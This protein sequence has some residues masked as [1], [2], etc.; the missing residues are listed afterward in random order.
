MT[1]NIIG[2]VPGC[3]S[4]AMAVINVIPN[5]TIAASSNQSL[6]CAGDQATLTAIGGITYTWTPSGIGS[7][8]VVSPTVTTIYMVSG[9][10]TNVCVGTTSV[11]QNVSPCTNFLNTE[12]NEEQIKIFPNP[13]KDE[14]KIVS[15][16]TFQIKLI[17][18][19]GKEILRIE[20]NGEVIINTTQ[21]SKG[22]YFIH[23]IGS[24]SVK[25]IKVIKD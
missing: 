7:V 16:E 11:T 1:Y 13:F 6:L 17:D 23:V 18:V 3:T 4:S 9:T 25:P 19:S 12:I 15:I 24:P 2:S 8:I 5:P 14:L 20:I 10:G 22:I 21:L